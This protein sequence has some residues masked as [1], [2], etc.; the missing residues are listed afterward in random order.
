MKLKKI[1]E[2]INKKNYPILN[3]NF[4]TKNYIKILSQVIVQPHR[5]YNNYLYFRLFNTG[6]AHL[7]YLNIATYSYYDQRF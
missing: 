6:L 4:N 5:G 3:K 2:N 7:N 1:D